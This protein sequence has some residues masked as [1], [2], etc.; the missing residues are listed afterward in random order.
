MEALPDLRRRMVG[1]QGVE[2]WTHGLKGR[3]STLLSY[4]PIRNLRWEFTNTRTIALRVV[5][6]S[7]ISVRSRRFILLVLSDV[8]NCQPF[9]LTSVGT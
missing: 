7:R 9:Y 2:P 4:Q 8:P 6:A 5:W 3:C 1:W